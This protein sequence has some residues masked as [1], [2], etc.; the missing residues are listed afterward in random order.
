MQWEFA[1]RMDGGEREKFSSEYSGLVYR[2]S[3]DCWSGV[4]APRHGELRYEQNNYR[5]GCGDWIRVRQSPRPNLLGSQGRFR[6]NPE[7]ARRTDQPQSFEQGWLDEEFH[8]DGRHDHHRRLSDQE[9]FSRNL[10]S[11]SRYE[12]RRGTSDGSRELENSAS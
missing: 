3:D 10:D 4:R 2:T 5:K 12:Q 7:M 9:R 6:G 1:N 8:Q 11:E